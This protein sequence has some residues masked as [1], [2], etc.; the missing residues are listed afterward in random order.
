M[1]LNKNN[2][3]KNRGRK[4]ASSVLLAGLILCTLV[5]VIFSYATSNHIISNA[6]AQNTPPKKVLI[7]TTSHNIL[8]KTG[9]PTGVWLPEMTH[10]F[11]ALQNAGFN[12]TIASVN[13][14][15]VPIDPYSIPSNP[16][17]TNRD[18]PIT[19]KF[20]HTPADVA[21]I[22]HTVP[23]STVNAREYSAVVFPG[24]NGATYDF[25][26]DKNVNRI[27]AAIYEQ[28]GIVAAVCHGPAAL[29]N[30]TLSNGQYLIKGM[31][32]TGFS[33]EEEAITEILIGKKHVLPFFLENELPKHGAIYEKVYVHEPLVVV[34]GNGRLITGQNPESATNVGEKVVEILKGGQAT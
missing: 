12:I 29:L 10:P 30:A 26:W 22:N 16:Q 11:S 9:Y 17:G 4:T 14:G 2:E 27:A 18:D 3:S 34:S 32:V 15:N 5:I 20:L 28:G 13:G 19:D 23:V 21:I 33:N 6:T 25:P 31:K 1:E 7:V 8:G 24:G